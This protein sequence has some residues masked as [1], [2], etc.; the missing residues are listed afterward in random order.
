METFKEKL[1]AYKQAV[2]SDIDK[3][4]THLNER[5]LQSYGAHSQIVTEAYTQLLKRGGKRIRGALTI[6]GYEMCGGK[7]T[8]MIIQAAR[9]VEMMHAYMLVID[10]IQDRADTRRAGPSVHKLLEAAHSEHKWR[11]TGEHTGVSLALNAALLGSHGAQMVIAALDVSDE[12]KVKAM[13]IMNNTMVVTAHGQSNDIINEINSR[14]SESD[15]EKVMQWKTAHYTV[16]NPLH[17][18]MVLAGAGCEDTNAI[19]EYAL[20]LG[21]AFQIT[22]DLMVL[23]KDNGKNAITDIREGK[24]TLLT[25]FA[26]Q[27]APVKDVEFLSKCLGNLDLTHEDFTRCQKILIDSGAREFASG[28]AKHHVNTAIKS[29]N[30]HAARWDDES[31]KFLNDLAH[32]VLTRTS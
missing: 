30:Q 25:F 7:D 5:T 12:L 20:S 19:T 4:C 24:Q 16:L 22:D 27:N 6:V 15:I 21:K 10:D 3:Y 32:F 29:L 11:D 14:V 18:G 13:N 17:M 1:A 8:K 28:I 26:Q 9:A 23:Q 2:D 31:V